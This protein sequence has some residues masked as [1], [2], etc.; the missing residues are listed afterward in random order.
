MKKKK[1]CSLLL[2]KDKQN[3][4]QGGDPRVTLMYFGIMAKNSLLETHLAY[5]CYI[6]QSVPFSSKTLFMLVY[7]PSLY[8]INFDY[9]AHTRIDTTQQR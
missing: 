3:P 9:R 8:T 4:P 7:I 1:I 5:F 6:P 2:P